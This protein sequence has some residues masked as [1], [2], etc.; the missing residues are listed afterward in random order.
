MNDLDWLSKN[1]SAT[2]IH[3]Q[4][5]IYYETVEQY[6]LQFDVKENFISSKEREL[7]IQND[8]VWEI[9]YYPDTPVCSCSA[10]ASSLNALKEYFK[11]ETYQQIS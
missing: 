8:E 6:M 2:I 7:S 3:N 1:I 11:N 10:V 9:Y 5:K 4:H